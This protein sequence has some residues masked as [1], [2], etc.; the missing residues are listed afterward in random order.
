MRPIGT[1]A[2]RRP[3]H[4]PRTNGDLRPKSYLSTN[5]RAES[6]TPPRCKIRNFAAKSL[7]RMKI[8]LNPAYESLRRFIEELPD[9]FD[10]GG[11]ML[12]DGRNRLKAFETAEVRLVVKRYERANLRKALLYTFVR[13]SKA[14]LAYEHAERLRAAGFDSPEPWIERRERGVIRQAWFVSLRSDCRALAKASR[15]FPAPESRELLAAFARWAVRLHQAGIE[16]RDFNHSNILYR[17]DPEI[18]F[19]LIDTNRMRVH[20]RPLRRRR[21][22]IN[23]RRLACPAPAYLF[24]MDRYADA[25]GWNTDQTI[26]QGALF[27]LSRQ[28]FKQRF[29]GLYARPEAKKRA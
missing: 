18:D 5:R 13:G 26:L 25:R 8:H 9:R 7:L 22:L 1:A 12:H 10:A 21:A 24:L 20:G 4:T 3:Q 11:E 17:R 2:G 19:Q 14:R 6:D 28:W 23:L 27:R 29:H 15:S 16:H